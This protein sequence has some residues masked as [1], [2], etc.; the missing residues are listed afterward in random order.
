MK[1]TCCE[2]R[3][4]RSTA[5][6]C[7]SDAMERETNDLVFPFTPNSKMIPNFDREEHRQVL[8]KSK[9]NQ[10]SGRKASRT[11]SVERKGFVHNT[12]SIAFHS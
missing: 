7:E 5:G 1:I 10:N 11:I 12:L 8:I 6:L 4:I 2:A 9:I 3:V